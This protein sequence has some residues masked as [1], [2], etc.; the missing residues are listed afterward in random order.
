MFLQQMIGTLGRAFDD[1]ARSK[2]YSPLSDAAERHGAVQWAYH[3]HDDLH[4]Y[5]IYSVA[6]TDTPYRGVLQTRYGADNGT[7]FEHEEMSPQDID[8]RGPAIP[9]LPP[10]PFDRASALQDADLH[11]K[12]VSASDYVPPRTRSASS[13]R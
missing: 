3:K 11:S 10:D 13:R 9:S 1:L 5:V 7:S 4:R 8:L 12:I 6:P 2:G